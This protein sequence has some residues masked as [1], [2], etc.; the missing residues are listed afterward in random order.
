MNDPAPTPPRPGPDPAAAAQDIALMLRVAEG[1]QTAFVELF[2]RY[3]RKVKAFLIAGGAPHDQADEIAQEVLVSVW[4]R[5]GQYDPQ[6]AAVSTWIFAI[7]RNRRIDALR[8]AGRPAPDP[9]DPLFQPDPEP[10]PETNLSA[11]ARDAVV[12]EAVSAL[13]ADQQEVVRLAFFHGLAQS[14]ISERLDIPLGTVKSRLRLAF[15]KL[16]GALGDDFSQE[17]FDD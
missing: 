15:K 9:E 5:A 10:D 14:E 11:A 6:K 8:R 16:R 1:D 17:L 2:E 3:A 13:P 7:A 12:R 4:R